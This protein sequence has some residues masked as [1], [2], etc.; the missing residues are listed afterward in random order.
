M[1]TKYKN[2]A[3]ELFMLKT[4]IRAELNQ[5]RKTYH[6]MSGPIKSIEKK[7]YPQKQFEKTLNVEGIHQETSRGKRRISVIHT[8]RSVSPL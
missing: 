2:T 7:H 3:K 8:E 1:Q 5:L 4:Q 6:L